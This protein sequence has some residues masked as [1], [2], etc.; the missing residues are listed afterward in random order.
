MAG[1]TVRCRLGGLLGFAAL[2]KLCHVQG[3]RQRVLSGHKRQA[4]RGD[5]GRKG[6]C[7]DCVTTLP[8]GRMAMQVKTRVKAGGITLNHN[9]TLVRGTG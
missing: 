6:C 5:Q 7:A 1:Q 8:E 2:D 9:E 3:S 4:P